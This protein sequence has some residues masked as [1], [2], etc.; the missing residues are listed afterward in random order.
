MKTLRHDCI[1]RTKDPTARPCTEACIIRDLGFLSEAMNETSIHG[2]SRY[3]TAG[4]TPFLEDLFSDN[5]DLAEA[6]QKNVEDLC[7]KT[8]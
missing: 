2:V 3:G 6:V 1:L 7:T 4:V 5:Q 8:S